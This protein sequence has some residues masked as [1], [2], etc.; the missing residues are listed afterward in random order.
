M[1]DGYHP[2]A[3]Y[4]IAY[5]LTLQGDD[6]EEIA[7]QAW[8]MADHPAR[9]DRK[10]SMAIGDIICVEDDQQYWVAFEVKGL[11]FKELGRDVPLHIQIKGDR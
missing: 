5:R 4:Q 3:A 7:E 8:C 1:L 11:G 2:D 10:R 6:L 9:E